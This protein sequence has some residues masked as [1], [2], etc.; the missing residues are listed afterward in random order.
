MILWT[1]TN[2]TIKLI[3]LLTLSTCSNW[4]YYYPPET[5]MHVFLKIIP[6]T[7]YNFLFLLCNYKLYNDNCL[8]QLAKGLI[9]LRN[10]RL[11]SLLQNMPIIKN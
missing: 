10:S 8:F 6:K 3:K 2:Y 1:D 4:T 11:L 5:I 7:V 9:H